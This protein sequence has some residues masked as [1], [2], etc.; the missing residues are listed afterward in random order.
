L[1]L[2]FVSCFSFAH[3]PKKK[4]QKS[5]AIQDASY[6]VYND[7]K[8]TYEYEKN[9]DRVRPIASVTKLMTAMVA[10]NYDLNMNRELKIQ[11][12][13]G[14]TLPRSG[15]Y[16]R[17]ELFSAMLV[18]SD[19]SAAETLA[20]DYPGGREAFI[21]EM[22]KFSNYIGMKN[23]NFDDP[24]GLSAT[25]TSTATDVAMMIAKAA[26]YTL[27]RE[28]ST[29][30]QIEIETQYKRKIRKLILNNTNKPVL[31]SF[32]DI[33]V[34]KTGFTSRAGYC[35]GLAVERNGQRYSVVILG[36]RNKQ[37]RIS[38]AEDI[39]YNHI[40]DGETMLDN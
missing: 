22:N 19:N 25:N 37:A 12:K 40:V 24:T 20:S 15:K 34:S 30:K 35:L 10:L 3:E 14:G 5:L 36:S 33:V 23:T 2:A 21:K 9:I 28:T 27:I 18:R 26:Q 4:K 17:H 39:L 31:F 8:S 16:T 13:V 29:K 1:L 7:T 38:K 32:D 6:L 11:S